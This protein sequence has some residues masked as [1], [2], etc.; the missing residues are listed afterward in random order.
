MT[1]RHRL[2][3]RS[4]LVL[5]LPL[6]AWMGVIFFLSAQ[7]NLPKL[8]HGWVDTLLSYGAHLF[9]YAILAVLLARALGGKRHTLLLAF[10]LAIV[11]ALSDEFHQYFVPGRHADP[12]DLMMD[13]F[14]AVLGLWAWSRLQRLSAGRLDGR[15]RDQR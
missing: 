10:V 12:K 8:E 5:W 15:A 11:Y 9:E 7:P 6:V 13:A 1:P 3:R 4:R 14:G 2:Q